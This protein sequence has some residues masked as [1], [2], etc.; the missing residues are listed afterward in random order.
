[1]IVTVKTGV[2]EDG[3]ILARYVKAI[4]DAGAYAEKGPTVLIQGCRGA[5]GPYRIPNVK[6]EGYLVYTNK[7]PADAY[8]GY[9]FF[10]AQY[11]VERQMDIIAKKLGLDPLEFRLKN[12]LQ[13]GDVNPIGQ[14]VVSCGLEECLRNV[15]EA[16]RWKDR[17]VSEKKLVGKGIACGFKNTKTPSISTVSL[18][19]R[20]DGRII[21][22]TTA[23]EEGQGSRH[24]LAKIVA[25]VLNVPLDKVLIIS[26]DTQLPAWDTSTTSS[27]TTFHQGNAI[28]LAAEKLIKSL[29]EKI[30]EKLNV[31]LDNIIFDGKVFKIN[32]EEYNVIDLAKKVL[33]EKEVV[34][35]TGHYEPDIKQRLWEHPG[36]FWMYAA[37]GAVVEVCPDTGAVF[38]KKIVIADD[39]GKAI[40]PKAVEQQL[41]GG[42]IQGLGNTLYE[43][44][45][46][47]DSGRILNPNFRDYKIPT[48]LE[49]SEDAVQAIIIEK[50]HPQGPFGAKGVGEMPLVP[51]HAAIV[52]AICNALG[53]E[54]YDLPITP[55]KILLQLK[56]AKREK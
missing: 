18:E 31:S 48:T 27:R 7:I 32:G 33:S 55:E 10:Q 51:V 38:I 22:Y 12:L 41:I 30:A 52:N 35:A 15:A 24:T 54:F 21:L 16:I 3:E 50:P 49:V 44:L 43:E 1:A 39:V 5:A 29:R 13:E 4:Y 40:D 6:I 8:R 14:E 17:K 45:V 46:F 11:A 26:G 20:W 34:I 25:E 28:L 19:L 47:S 42:I 56:H 9:G 53:I 36:I 2:G 37:V 23:I